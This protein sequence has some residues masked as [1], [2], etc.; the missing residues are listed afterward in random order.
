MKSGLYNSGFYILKNNQDSLQFLGWLKIKLFD[1]CY[2]APNAYMFVDQ[3][4]LDFAPILF[5][6]VGIY[7]NKTYN[8]GHWNFYEHKLEYKDDNYYIEDEKLTFFHFS[9]LAIDEIDISN[10]SLFNTSFRNELILQRISAEYWKYLKNNGHKKIMDIP[11]THK[12][13]YIPPPLSFIDPL[14]SKSIEL[15]STK[16]ELDST[17]ATLDSMKSRLSSTVTELSTT[18]MRLNSKANELYEIYYSRG[19]RFIMYARK[20]LDFL[21]PNEELRKKVLSFLYRNSKK[22]VKDCIKVREKVSGLSLRCA[23]HIIKP[24]PRKKR[25]INNE[26]KKVVFVDHSGHSK[27]KS[28]EFILDY[29]KE[30]YDVKIVFDDSWIGKPFPDLSFID[31]SYLCVIFLQLVPPISSIKNI[32]NDNIVYFPMYDDTGGLD[33]GFWNDYRDLKIINFSKTL[34]D[35]LT[36]WGFE[37]IYVQYFPKPIG[38]FPGNDNEIFFWQRLTELNVKTVSN[39]FNRNGFRMHLHKAVSP[40]QEFIPPSRELEKRF[41]ITYSDWFKD[42]NEMLEIIRKKAIYIAPREYEGIGMSFLEA[43]AMGKAVIA[44]NNP[45][46]N[47]YIMDR[48]N[49]YLFDPR[50]PKE[51]DLSNMEKVQ[52]NCYEFMKIGYQKWEISKNKIIEFIEQ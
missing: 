33:L 17:K 6:Y 37:S 45:T 44:V 4:I 23:N 12:E 31:E 19:W 15:N 24:K 14:L 42:R 26:S 41:D 43:M 27:T 3:K 38:F 18:K 21:I 47:E 20:I 10:S 22:G 5:D 9:Q 30:F 1:H 25:K 49:G 7:R 46:M 8:V 36:N 2:N 29:L 11:Y 52:K 35:K 32:K 40:G 39:L 51:I 34:N 48:K 50:N 13:L 28:T 16:T